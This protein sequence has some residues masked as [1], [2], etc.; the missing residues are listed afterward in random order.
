MVAVP[1]FAAKSAGAVAVS[2]AVVQVTS[3]FD[4]VG[5]DN[6]IVKVNGVVPALPSLSDTSPIETVGVLSSLT[7]VPMP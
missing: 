4:V 7:I 1:P 6:V 2:G 3:T 5:F